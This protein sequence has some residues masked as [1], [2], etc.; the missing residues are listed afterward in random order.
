MPKR[1][2]SF[3]WTKLC[4]LGFGCA[5]VL[6]GFVPGLAAAERFAVAT[7]NLEGYIL[8]PLQRRSV[9][10]ELARARIHES[11]RALN[12]DVLGLQEVGGTNA[13]LELRSALKSDGLEYPYWELV[14]G[15]DPN[16]QVALLSRFPFRA[17]HSHSQDGFLL[18]GRRFRLTRGIVEV[19][20]QVRDNYWFTLFVVHLKSKVPTP[21]ADEADLREQEALVLREK[22]D[23]RLRAN[24]EMN[25]AVVGDLND[26]RNSRPVRAVLGRGKYAL[27]DTRPAEK[28]GDPVFQGAARTSGRAVTWTHF[29]SKED[30]YSRL[31][32]ILL[33]KG[34]AREW[35][36][37]GTYVLSEPNWGMASDH[38]PVV[39][40]FTTRD[41]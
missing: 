7:Y 9:K 33:S 28:N 39:A 6:P 26:L 25:L 41:R 1:A 17:R 4:L 10:P 22:I 20:V 32:Y 12:A 21:E 27:V 38:R 18:N 15:F 23:A 5:L 2:F 36:P 14:P 37:A 31:D 8:Q 34:M 3:H 29:Y 24:P 11:I 35:E 30:T 40:S 13:L 16:I 19:D